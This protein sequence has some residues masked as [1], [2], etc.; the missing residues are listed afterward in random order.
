MPQGPIYTR[1]TTSTY[2]VSIRY[3]NLTWGYR[4]LVH[5]QR[6]QRAS[7]PAE[8]VS[9]IYERKFETFLSPVRFLP[10]GR[11]T[12][13]GRTGTA[14]ARRQ[15]RHIIHDVRGALQSLEDRIGYRL[16]G[17]L[18]I[19][20]GG[21]AVVRRAAPCRGGILNPTVYHTRSLPNTLP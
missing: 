16:I 15:A 2:Q 4:Y 6:V 14:G 7:A 17:L 8:R 5:K 12:H 3:L 13:G 9:I 10:A 21:Q 11:F 18:F 20:P 1:D 19:V